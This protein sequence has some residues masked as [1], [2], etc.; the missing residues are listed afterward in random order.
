MYVSFLG[1]YPPMPKFEL[2]RKGK[3]FIPE[4]MISSGDEA[5]RLLEHLTKRRLKSKPKEGTAEWD[6]VSVLVEILVHNPFIWCAPCTCFQ[7]WAT[8]FGY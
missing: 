7:C 3:V 6:R 4:E 2:A 8:I 5:E 1:P